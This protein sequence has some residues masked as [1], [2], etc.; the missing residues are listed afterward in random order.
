MGGYESAYKE[1]RLNGVRFIRG[2]PSLVRATPDGRLLVGGENTLLQELYETRCRH[3]G[4]KRRPAGSNSTRKLMGSLDIGT[5]MESL[6]PVL[7]RALHPCE[8]MKKGVFLAGSVES[9][10][11]IRDSLLHANACATVVGEFLDGQGSV[12]TKRMVTPL[13][14][15]FA[16]FSLVTFSPTYRWGSSTARK[17]LPS[18]SS[19][20]P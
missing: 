10:K 6:V 12:G 18:R 19:K 7:D 4:P 1:A 8:T 16:S 11:D 14:L 20:S 9:P 13:P 5:D 2:Q 15:A 17:M 3:G